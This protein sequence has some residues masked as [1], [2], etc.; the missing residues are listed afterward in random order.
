MVASGAGSAEITTGLDSAVVP[1]HIVIMSADLSGVTLRSVTTGRSASYRTADLVAGSQGV[2]LVK[3]AL[4]HV[5][6]QSW[7]SRLTDLELIRRRLRLLM[8]QF[9]PTP[10]LTRYPESERA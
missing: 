5:S 4:R 8:R 9:R 10:W 2:T 1:K 7:R 3:E 6:Y